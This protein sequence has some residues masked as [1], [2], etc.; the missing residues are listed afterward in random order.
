M[1]QGLIIASL[2]CYPQPIVEG[3][4]AASESG[5]FDS[6]LAGVEFN[7]RQRAAR[8]FVRI[9][10]RIPAAILEPLPPLLAESPDPDWALNM[11]E[12]LTETGSDE[13]FRLLS[14]HPFLIHYAIVVF[15]Y[16]QWLGDTLTQNTDIFHQLA[17]ERSLELSHSREDYA[18]AF[19]RFRS[20]SL[21]T[22]MSLLL[23][24]FKRR[25]YIRILLRDVL[26]IATLAE[27]TAEISAVS[28]VMID[29]ALREAA[30][31][32]RNRFGAP[33]H[34]DKD[35][36]LMD[37]TFAVLSLGKLGGTELNYSSDIDLLFIHEDGLEGPGAS[38]SN[39]E[40]FV[41]LG[42]EVT[43]ILSRVT[44]EGAP[45][46]IDL[47]LRPQGGEGDTAVGLSHA[48][49][50]YAHRA[51]DWELQAL[52]KIR[53]AAGDQ[54]LARDFIRRVQ[55]FVYTEQINFE[56]IETAIESRD[57]MIAR[58]RRPIAK[59]VIDVK[60][61]R[62]G[63]RDV[64]FIVQCL[65]RVYGGTELWLRSGGTLFSLQKLHDK[66]HITGKEFHV[67]TIAYEFLRNIEHR[68]QLRQGQQTQ[69]LPQAEHDLRVL[70]RSI[71]TEQTEA[72]LP[73]EMVRV[74]KQRMAAVS[75]IYRRIIHHQ[76]LEKQRD[77]SED[78]RSITAATGLGWEYEQRQL[79]GRLADDAPELCE[80]ASR[81]DLHA[82][83]RRNLHRFLASVL[84]NVEWYTAVARNAAAV[85]QALKLFGASEYLTDLLVRHPEEVAALNSE[86]RS[87]RDRGS[88]RIFE[89]P[90]DPQAPDPVFEY[91]ANSP[92][93]YE[94]K[95]A[96]LRRY[97]RSEI[98][99]LAARDVLQPRCI[100]DSLA[101][102]SAL[103][104]KSIAA[105]FSIAG[106]PSGLS[107]VALGRLGTYESD[108][109]SDADLIFLRDESLPT[110]EAAKTAGVLMEV[111]SAYTKQG[112]VF[113]VDARLRPNGGDGALV[114]TPA[115]LSSYF[116]RSAQPWEALTYTKMRHVA[117]NAE[118]AAEAFA[119]RKQL[120]ERFAAE[121]TF[122]A[123][124]REMR[125]RLEH[126]EPDLASIK[127]GP[128]GFY[129]LDYIVGYLLVRNGLDHTRGNIGDS[130]R[131]LF[132][133][134]LLSHEE[135]ET[136]A[137]AGLLLRTV[138]HAVRVVLGKTRKSVPTAG[139][140]RVA[141]EE[142]TF[143]SLPD[144]SVRDLDAVLHKT[145]RQVR[146]VYEK[147]VPP[148]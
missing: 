26:G 58:R 124:V 24:R 100:Y 74:V 122:T 143:E 12:R 57:R 126:S 108:L 144:L 92:G 29:E 82:H 136:L 28:D 148:S 61:D 68:L 91:L 20:R 9:A 35:G 95:L 14:R 115:A 5:L 30:L 137:S 105:A 32:M 54:R 23:A 99:R 7:D 71:T 141:V 80:L 81:A 142:L 63:I 49:D 55:P 114:I 139:T 131:E 94:E 103:A 17:R 101:A 19:A 6:A 15:G 93:S 107:I 146:T 97:Y 96:L 36:R 41:R 118:I 84:T 89:R 56:A 18:E 46:R 123:A 70:E 135:C 134:G 43:A 145:F 78:F 47:R 90:F 76:Q 60:T 67:L 65:Q 3:K 73:G 48:L 120:F 127:T 111:L 86:T 13:L 72:I 53:Y 128:G 21:D 113:P 59:G 130:V 125:G 64:E 2:P 44:R 42:Q 75:E 51:S 147:L 10:E 39:H 22:D 140:A 110:A 34:V 50:Y 62:G 31:I 85:N 88:G 25:E 77:A 119:A 98:F 27:T 1:P 102:T 106:S 11:F 16:S 133:R 83:T 138:E 129:D 117:G 38:I 66:G 87:W 121:K 45:F 8:D 52:I 33:Q 116:L 69:R 104:D 132:K 40:Y 112:T 109:L 4:R 37:T 79:L